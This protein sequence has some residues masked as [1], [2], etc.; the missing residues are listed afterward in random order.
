MGLDSAASLNPRGASRAFGR[1]T[2]LAKLAIG[3]MAELFLA[4]LTGVV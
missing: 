4:R 1:Y 3:G 2:L